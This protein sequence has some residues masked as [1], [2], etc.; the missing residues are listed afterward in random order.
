MVMNPF[1]YKQLEEFTITDCELYISKYPYGEHVVEVKRLLRKL[2][3]QK[4][5]QDEIENTTDTPKTNVETKHR[6]PAKDVSNN[7]SA[8]IVNATCKSDDDGSNFFRVIG[9]IV[10]IAIVIAMTVENGR[11]VFWSV[12]AA[13]CVIK[14]IWYK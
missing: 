3:K 1:K 5:S 10:V 8:S 13:W 7:K 4:A 9:T 2:K 11:P 6:K 12:F 14:A